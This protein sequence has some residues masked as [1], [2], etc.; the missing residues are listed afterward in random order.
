MHSMTARLFGLLLLAT[1]VVWSCGMAW[2]YAGSRQELERVLDTRLEE[3]TR[4]VTSLMESAGV[5][6]TGGIAGA[7]VA[8]QSVAIHQ[9][10]TNFRLACQIWSV[11]G[12]LVGKSSDAPT[13][14]L[15][16]VDS[17]YSDRVIDGS[18]WRV[19]AHVDPALGI[20]VL[21]GDSVQHRERLVRELMWGLAIPGVVVLA[22]LSAL[23]WIALREGLEPLR[24]L[25]AALAARSPDALAPLDIGRSPAEIRPVVEALNGLF[26]KVAAAREHERSVTAYAAHE[27]RTPLAGLRTQVQIALAAS[28]PATRYDALR[29]ALTA[30]D[31]TT[32]MAGQLLAMAQVDATEARAPQEWINAGARLKAVCEELR[33]T[34]QQCAPIIDDCLFACRIR[35]NPDAFHMVVR[36]LT[37]NALQHAQGPVPVRWSLIASPAAALLTVEDSGPGIPDDEIDVVTKRFFRGRH[38]SAIG[39]G[40]GL[41]IAHTALEKDGLLLHLE[42]RSPEPGLR[43]QIVISAERFAVDPE[44]PAAA[45]ETNGD[46]HDVAQAV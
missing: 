31:R 28:D 23:I 39:S 35:V 42:N 30:A 9:H 45:T 40:L 14:Q 32:R 36:N 37:E 12:R 11:D 17:G 13:T 21:V 44:P 41:S 3:A 24:R 26:D 27:L 1:T 16:H 46:I 34:D 22:A 2:I 20:R 33:K 5:H 18:R 15:T 29:N 7:R 19:F 4:M 10:D 6:V 38:K 8:N 25:T 43:A